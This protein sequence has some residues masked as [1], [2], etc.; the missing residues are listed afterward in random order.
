[1]KSLQP[2]S[3]VGNV[4]Q[5]G[6]GSMESFYGF[7]ASPEGQ[8]GHWIICCVVRFEYVGLPIN[9]EQALRQAWTSLRYRFPSLESTVSDDTRFCETPGNPAAEQWMK[10]TYQIHEETTADELFAR[11]RSISHITLHYLPETKQLVINAPH[12]LIDGRG[13]L[14]LY[15]ELF[16]QLANPNQVTA[17]DIGPLP[18]TENDLLGL[19]AVPTELDVQACQKLLSRFAN[20]SPLVRM[21]NVKFDQAPGDAARVELKLSQEMTESIIAACKRNSITVTAAWHA[22]VVLA[23]SEIQATAGETG[24]TFTSFTNFDMRR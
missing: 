8:I 15:N 13:I 17:A 23:V 19:R 12:S 4:W 16:N 11:L 21:P 10:K 5:R 2:W 18:P 24:S 6:T 1:M 9:L 3:Q 7:I 22:A 20:P 14:H